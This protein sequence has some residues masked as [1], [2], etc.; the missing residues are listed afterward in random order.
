MFSNIILDLKYSDNY[1]PLIDFSVD[2]K[3]PKYHFS[4]YV[5]DVF[6]TR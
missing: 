2:T 4:F 5:I 1:K 6:S 3:L